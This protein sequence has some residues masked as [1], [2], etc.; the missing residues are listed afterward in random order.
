MC[1][2]LIRKLHNHAI[3]NLPVAQGKRMTIRLQ[4]CN[5][6][7]T[8]HIGKL[9]GYF[10]TRVFSSI[11]ATLCLKKHL[12]K[13]GVIMSN[14]NIYIIDNIPLLGIINGKPLLLSARM[15]INKGHLR[16][17]H[18]HAIYSINIFLWKFHSSEIQLIINMKFSQ[19]YFFIYIVFTSERRQPRDT[20]QHANEQHR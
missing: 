17:I 5:S 7:E 2:P 19:I 15:P 12:T 13:K 10:K 16:Y 20:T 4:D 18:I 9:R 6:Q 14:N 11:Y 8:H 3:T 1:D